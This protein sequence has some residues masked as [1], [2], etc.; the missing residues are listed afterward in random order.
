MNRFRASLV[1]SLALGLTACQDNL[2][3]GPAEPSPELSVGG[4]VVGQ[5]IV[6][7]NDD[8]TD[9]PGLARQLVAGQG[10][11]LGRTWSSAIKGFSAT[12]A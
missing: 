3:N 4:Q 12:L 8:V 10:G 5:Y 2:I 6:V 1:V 7:F 9:P 11:V